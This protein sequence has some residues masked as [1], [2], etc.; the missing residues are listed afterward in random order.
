MIN[1]LGEVRPAQLITTFGPGAIVDSV[2]D[3]VTVLDI[4]YW[5]NVGKKI[6]DIRLASYLGVEYFYEPRASFKEDIPVISFPDYHV[7][8]SKKCSHLFNL[9]DNFDLD[10]YLKYGPTC[11]KC[12]KSA[13]PA[14]FIISCRKGHMDDFPW[15]WWA[16]EGDTNCKKDMQLIA[17]GRTSSLA[18]LE[19]KCSCGAKKSMKGATSRSEFKNYKCTGRH[20][21]RPGLKNIDCKS[22]VIPL[23]RGASNVYFPVIRSAI[24]IPPWINPIDNLLDDH[25][26]M[27]RELREFLGEEADEKVYDKYFKEKYSLDEYKEALRRRDEKIQEYIEIKEMEYAAI[28][29]FEDYEYRNV[30]KYFKAS[31]EELPPYLEKYFKRLIKVQRLREVMVLLGFI[32]NEFPEPE[33]DTHEGMVELSK[34]QNDKWLPAVTIHGEGIFIEFNK[35]EI[36]KWKN[37]NEIEDLS[38][39]Y[40]KYYDEY[41]KEKG[42]EN[43]K[44]RDIEYVLI[45]TFAHIM[46]KELSLKCGYSSTSIKERIYHSDNM[47]GVLLYTGS[48]DKEGSLGGLVEMGKISNFSSIL[49]SALKEA[50]ICTTDPKCMEMTPKK[51][52]LHGAS[53]HSCTMISETSCET[54]NRLLDRST[55]LSLSESN[56]KGYFDELVKEKCG[57]E[58]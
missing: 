7:C 17:K 9:Q 5:K 33:I 53:C 34:N 37:D 13:Y 31:E 14:R 26:K 28:T 38:N 48:S 58:I 52:Q 1:K 6:V 16:H 20:P 25:Y 22:E 57:I 4:N 39:K 47:C 11:P 36:K 50:I 12:N 51:D 27:I 46:I 45:H 43:A 35:D 8:S 15:R 19:V 54:G 10:K 44:S 41:I 32:R 23:Q 30:G 18:D 2:K 49:L 3:S 55:L 21:H 42:W 29:N 24:S 56:I 40:K